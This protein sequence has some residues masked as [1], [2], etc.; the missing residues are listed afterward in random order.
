M[1]AE[2]S[3]SFRRV[4]LYLAEAVRGGEFRSVF[5][6]S[7]TSGEGTT[8][9]ILET[10]RH[11]RQVFGLRTLVIEWTRKKP[12]LAALLG[13]RKERTLEDCVTQQLPLGECVQV[14]EPGLAVLPASERASQAGVSSDALQRML[15]Q[16]G[17]DYDVVL[18][19]AP[20]ILEQADAFVVGR[21]IPHMVLVVRA[22]QTSEESVGNVRDRMTA[23]NVR[24]VG[25]VL[26]RHRTILPRWISRWLT[27]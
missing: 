1:P 14:V 25:A 20:P 15:V 8:T 26:N 11:L 5:F 17:A 23:A 21:A 27:K 4:A 13:L 12:G 24:I 18:V 19:D 16:A 22:G 10:A 6:A 2:I 7:A 9:T 3:E